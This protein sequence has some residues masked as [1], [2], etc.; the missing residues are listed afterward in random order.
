MPRPFASAVPGWHP[1]AL[2]PLALAAWVYW[3]ITWVFFWSDDFVHLT[4]IVNEGPLVFLLRPFG[5]Q[6]FLTRNLVFLGSYHLFGV[7]P[8]AFQWTMLLG[9][10]LNVWLLFGVLRALT[11]SAALACLGAALWGMSPLAVGSLGWYAIFGGVLVA[12]TLLLVLLWV[13]RAATAGGPISP[14][15]AAAWCAL[16]LIGSTCYGPGMGA[17]LASPVALFLILPAAWRQ[18]G[19]RLAFLALP[20]ATLALYFGLRQLYLLIDELSSQEVF[21]MVQA[22]SG[23]ERTPALFLHLLAYSAGRTVLGFFL[24]AEQVVPATW[25]AAAAFVAGVGL[26]LWRGSPETR[27]AALAMIALWMGIYAVI[28]AGRANVYW[29]LNIPPA[30]A[31]A[32][33]RYH[34]AATIP[35]VALLCLALRELGRLPGLR[36]VP[37]GAAAAAGLALLVWSHQRSD[38]RINERPL[39]HDYF[40]VTE[41]ELTEAIAAA[42]PGA[43]LYLENRVTPRY[44]LGAAIPNRLVPGRA[45]VFLLSRAPAA[46]DGRQ[47]RFVEREPDVLIEHRDRGTPLSRLLVAPEDVPPGALR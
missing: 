27:R 26:V 22:R 42:P 38:L 23:V 32:M 25:I 19:I 14:A 3:P 34:Y 11:A 9:H 1:A 40:L 28:A 24:P 13:T 45:A 29:F 37:A 12:T 18:R 35:I 33:A 10:L 5:G 21:H 30:V 43:T 8:V 46:L 17:A 44:V 6:A 39:V 31:A 41:R 15:A 2:L 16:L 36:A 4:E 47:V 7:D 20:V